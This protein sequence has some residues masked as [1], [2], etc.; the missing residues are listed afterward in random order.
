MLPRERVLRTPYFPLY[1]S[2]LFYAIYLYDSKGYYFKLTASFKV[3]DRELRSS[4]EQLE[5]KG[6]RQPL[7]SYHSLNI[8]SLLLICLIL[9]RVRREEGGVKKR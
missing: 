2:E 9:V 7:V 6:M 3:G 1:P 4:L 5:M 8:I